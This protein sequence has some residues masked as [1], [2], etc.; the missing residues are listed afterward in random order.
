MKKVLILIVSIIALMAG[1]VLAVPYFF[2]DK[3]QAK[4]NQE[5]AKKINAKVYYN[6]F[7]ISLIKHFPELTLSLSDFG[8]VGHAPF[9]ADTLVQAK[10]FLVSV[11][12]K[13]ILSGDKID[14]HAIALESP[15]ILIKTLRD[16]S[17]NYD[18]YKTDSLEVQKEESKENSNFKVNVQS[19]KINNGQIVYDDRLKDAYVS[20][21]NIIHEGSGDISA[22]VYD[23]VT[24][25]EIENA[26]IEY[27]GTNYLNDKKL[28]AD[29]NIHI[30]QVHKTYIFKDNVF[31]I[32]DLILNFAGS[33]ATPDTSNIVMDLTYSS[34]ENTFKNLLS[35]VPNIYT[36]KF[37]DLKADGNVVLGGI[38]KGTKNATKFPSFSNG[39]EIRNGMFQYAEMPTSV[40]DINITLNIQNM[41]DDLN[42]TVIDFRNIDLKFGANP[43]KGQI[44]IKGLQKSL[45][46][47]D[48]VAKL[49]LHQISQIFPMKGLEMRGLYDINLKAK[50]TYDTLTKQFP[51]VNA[52]MS[53]ANG[54]IKS[55]K[56]PEPIQNLNVKATLLNTDGALASTK[57]NIA[58]L[59]MV[60]DGEPFTANGIIQNFENYNWDIRAKGKLD[61]T[62]ITKIYPLTD[63]TLKGIIDA[64][65]TTKGAMSDVKAKRYTNLPTNGKAKVQGIEFASKAYPQGIK[66]TSADMTFTPQSINVSNSSGYLGT[67]DFNASGTFSNYIAYVLNDESLKGKMKLK[68][69]KFNVN[70]WM[71]SSPTPTSGGTNSSNLEVVEIPKNIDFVMDSEI[72][73]VLYDDMKMNNIK[74]LLTVGSGAVKMQNVAFQSLG[75]NFITNGTYNSADLAHPKF[76]FALNLE[77]VEITQAYQHLNIV[78]YLMPVAQ[79]LIGGV[80]SKFKI[81]GELGQ[82]MMPKINTLSGDGLMKILKGEISQDNPLVQKL[83]ETTK[84]SKLK[85]TKLNNLLMQFEIVDGTFGVKPFDIK[86]DDYKITA[87]G[88][89]GLVG[90]MNYALVLDVPAGKTGEAFS[91]I[92][93][94]WTG[95]TLQGTDRVKFDLSLAGTVKNPIFGFKGSST[96]NSLKD[97]VV[98]EAKAQIDAAKTKALEEADRLKKEAE[99]KLQVEK[100][101]LLHEAN[102]KKAEIE[103]RIQK[104]KVAIEAK[105]KTTVDSIKKAAADRA[106]KILEE[107]KKSVLDGLFKKNKADTT[108][109]IRRAIKN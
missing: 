48:L 46:D 92:F 96:A 14:V 38:I 53:L 9:R 82:D 27:G 43:I 58:D 69:Q 74:G 75:G 30:D 65:I 68:S 5:I 97:A 78:K 32:N 21:K 89:H 70:E 60:L 76:D 90:S 6:N 95:K 87:S 12:V 86:F 2:K 47:A 20:L 108:K 62:K 16:G 35:L 85:D 56:F 39:I 59:R 51:Q 40:K 36:D 49:D 88:R 83:V 72:G 63:M 67:S 1:I 3:I 103:A 91:N 7:D 45:I 28:S 8:V 84:L 4:V 11:D 105:A 26:I 54:F 107:Q 99:A 25:T 80:N 33:I 93:Q 94:K 29:I 109:N 24:K 10:E 61:L 55:D 13:S 104:E 42:N 44:L 41:T 52:V 77:N 81:N 50:G 37:K 22:N 34:P 79:Y 31:K 101:R 106:K 98:A 23:L 15:K 17:S 18:I 102:A 19:W 71:K 66:V 100:E 73:E 64:D 57:L